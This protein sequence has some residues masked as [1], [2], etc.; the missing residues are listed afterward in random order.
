MLADMTLHLT[1][2]HARR[3]QLR[4][5]GLAE[6]FPDV[7]AALRHHGFIQMDPINIC[8]RMHDLILR[9]RVTGYREGDL[10]RHTYSA[11]LADARSAIEHYLPGQG[12]LV[13]FPVAAW[14]WLT[15]HM[16]RRAQAT[17]GH[18]GKLS[19]REARVADLI[20]RELAERGPLTSD[21]IEHDG[22]AYSGWGT[23]VRAVKVVLEK[24][25]AHGRVLISDRRQFRRV[26]DLPERVL[27]A[28]VLTAPEPAPLDQERWLIQQRLRQRRLVTLRKADAPVVED[29][30]QRVEVPDCPPLF[31]LRED[32]ELL[33]R[34]DR[35]TLADGETRLLAPLDPLIYDRKLTAKLWNFDYTWEVYTPPGRR[36]RGY[37]ALPVLAG[38]QL[39]GHID[40]KADRKARRLIVVGR[41]AKRGH[42]TRPALQAL[43]KFLGLRL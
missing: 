24:L 37:Y 29:L 3:F 4:A 17:R 31:C 14:P 26:Y 10:L 1:A 43:A 34:A 7:A 32:R 9:Q 20:L 33:E 18:A 5:L 41:K 39:V 40:P 21:D 16:R 2:E 19:A 36:T 11:G 35:E 38:D 8:G 42:P 12:I 13:T 23:P 6:P 27:P 30:V 28:H 22:R 25:F 15:A